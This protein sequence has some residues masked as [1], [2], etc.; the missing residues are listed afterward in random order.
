MAILSSV[1]RQP[2][3]MG[4]F[5]IIIL[6]ESRDAMARIRR[7]LAKRLPDVE[8]TEFDTEQQGKPGPDF[9]WSMYDAVFLDERLDMRE[10]GIDWLQEFHSQAAFPPAILMTTQG[11]ETVAARAIRRGA[12]DCIK[13]HDVSAERIEDLLN[14]QE[15]IPFGAGDLDATLPPAIAFT[16]W[17][18]ELFR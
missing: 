5:R 7:L 4:P 10:T 15:L 3:P 18:R 6:D 1:S 2:H 17:L 8:V 12:Y 13:K 16:A 9:D 14:H 11:D